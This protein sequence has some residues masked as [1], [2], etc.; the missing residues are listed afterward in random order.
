[1]SKPGNKT[2]RKARPVV[3]VSRVPLGDLTEITIRSRT[4]SGDT[5]LHRAAKNGLIVDIPHSLLSV[6]LFLL[7]NCRLETPMHLAAKNGQLTKVPREF[8]T[9]ETLS[10]LDYYGRSPLHIA[11]S[12]RHADQIPAE[13]LTPDLL[14]LRTQ[15]FASNTFLHLVAETNT[16]HLIPSGCVKDE[17]MELRNGHQLTPIEVLRV[18]LPTVS[19]VTL[20]KEL[21]V[22][23]CLTGLTKA[24][25]NGLIEEALEPIKRQF[26][27]SNDETAS[28]ADT[29]SDRDKTEARLEYVK[30]ETAVG[31]Q[32]GDRLNGVTFLVKSTSNPNKKHLVSVVSDGLTFRMRCSCQSR[33]QQIWMCKHQRSLIDND[34]SVLVDNSQII[35]L[36]RI[37]SLPEMRHLTKSLRTH[38]EKIRGFDNSIQSTWSELYALQ[39]KTESV[40]ENF[41]GS[42]E[43]LQKRLIDA[44]RAVV[45]PKV[46]HFES[47]YRRLARL[48]EER[49]DANMQFVQDLRFGASHTTP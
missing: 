34:R 24:R 30:M 13:L 33:Y 22:D 10:Q 3:T 18:S 1:M 47:L 26:H 46:A 17:L 9:G 12:Y 48:Q 7:G 14:R 11:A 49:R 42:V 5:P 25:A 41:Q 32:P 8:L 43:E 2:T 15:S 44:N 21:G 23:F 28:A 20:L 37:Q 27:A 4:Q 36:D 29:A 39:R 16:F 19:Q 35:L 45:I 6:D 40:N 31:E 38:E